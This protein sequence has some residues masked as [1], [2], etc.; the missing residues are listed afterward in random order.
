MRAV[1]SALCVLLDI[2]EQLNST[3]DDAKRQCIDHDADRFI[4]TI[5]KATRA[6]PHTDG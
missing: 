1:N 5:A 6:L 3:H 4:N 2:E